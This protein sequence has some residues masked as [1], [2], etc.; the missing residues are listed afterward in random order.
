Q[1]VGSY[2]TPAGQ[3][4]G[5]VLAGGRFTTVAVPSASMTLAFGINAAGQVGGVA[6]TH[7]F[8]FDR[9]T[10]TTF[11]APGA[12][13]TTAKRLSPSGQIVGYYFDG[14]RFHGFLAQ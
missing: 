1:I 2:L 4:C 12:V 3:Y 5:F 9:G 8:V 6:D 13:A 10:Y 14:Q 11:D 7:G